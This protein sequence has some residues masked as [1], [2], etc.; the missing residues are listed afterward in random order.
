MSLRIYAE[1]G[2]YSWYVGSWVPMVGSPILAIEANGA[3]LELIRSYFDNVPIHRGPI[4]RWK[5]PWAEFIVEALAK[6]SRTHW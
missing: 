5:E 1:S 2:E 4:V 3:E 6:H